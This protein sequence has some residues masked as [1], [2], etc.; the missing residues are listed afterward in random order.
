[1][2]VLPV[3]DKILQSTRRRVEESKAKRPAELLRERFGARRPLDFSAALSGG[4]I[5]VIAEV[6]RASPS[7]GALVPDLDAGACAFEYQ[8]HGAAAVSVLT[9][10]EF[11]GGSLADLDAARAA[12]AL[13]LLRKDFIVDEYQLLEARAHGADAVLLMLSVLGDTEFRQLFATTSELGLSA[14][15]EVHDETELARA[16]SAGARLIGINNRDFKTLKV[17]PAVALRLA[18]AAKAAGALVVGE[19]GVGSAAELAALSAAGCS[20]ALVGSHLMRSGRPGAALARL[21][22]RPVGTRVKVCGLTRAEDAYTASSLGAWALGF[23]FVPGTPRCLSVAEARRVAQG[24]GVGVLKVG[25]F[26]DQPESEA[27]AAAEA[28]GLDLIQLHGAE[29]DLMVDILGAG[30]CVKAVSLGGDAD[31]GA[32]AGRAARW[33]LV[34][35]P[36]GVPGAPDVDWTLAGKLARRR[37]RTLLAGG[38]TPLN[39]ETAMERARPWGVDVSSGVERSPGV[40]DGALLEDFFAG[41]WRADSQAGLL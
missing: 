37:P 41:V 25:V 24:A 28:C 7:Q 4:P 5:K 31:L 29:S 40:K 39:V 23:V 1:M 26:A 3:F 38:L 8:D 2:S 9:E 12:V 10:P 16:L 27:R 17:D 13:P 18:P 30:R 32:A 22:G 35:R 6:K 14:L 11:F 34:D 20:A 21:L 19:S 33:L 15:V 36:K